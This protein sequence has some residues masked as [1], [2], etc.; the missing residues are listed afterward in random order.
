MEALNRDLH[1]KD[2]DLL[3]SAEGD[4]HRHKLAGI[5]A[6]LADCAKCRGR[7]LE[8]E[9]IVGSLKEAVHLTFTP[10]VPDTNESLERLRIRMGVSAKK[11]QVASWSNLI[12]FLVSQP[13]ETY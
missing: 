4:L 5:R 2:E 8:F 3:L 6:H 7:L 12:T 1:P 9:S 10:E 11:P 13:R